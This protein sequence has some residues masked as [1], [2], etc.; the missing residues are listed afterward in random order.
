MKY[1]TL[2]WYQYSKLFLKEF[3]LLIQITLLILVGYL[4][5]SS[6]L[7]AYQLSDAADSIYGND[8]V[9]F[10]LH[11]RIIKIINGS[12]EFEE[13]EREKLDRDIKAALVQLEGT[14]IKGIGEIGR[15]PYRDGQGNIKGAMLYNADLIQNTNI[16]LIE[17]KWE[18]LAVK[19]ECIPI[20]VSKKIV[21]V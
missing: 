21:M 12:L 4:A 18:D 3:L 2:V 20:I 5:S 7:S 11:A 17:G 15:I 1:L 16:V 14:Q 13:R 8:M 19:S 10:D 6:F 9:Y